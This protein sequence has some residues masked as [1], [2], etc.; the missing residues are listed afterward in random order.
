MS[1]T[2]VYLNLD[3]INND[4]FSNDDPPV[5]RFEETRNAPFLDGDSSE[6][7]A[8]IIRFSIQTGNELPI[9]TPRIETGSTEMDVDRTVYK[10]TVVYNVNPI[11]VPLRWI[12][13]NSAPRPSS[14]VTSQ[15]ISTRYYY[16]NNFT[17]F[18]EML[19][20]ALRSTWVIT[21]ST[22][23]NAPFVDFDSMTNRFNINGDINYFVTGN[24]K[25]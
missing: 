17:Q 24:T 14:P 21:G 4:Q 3:I 1:D 6:Y 8:S 25:L 18:V 23:E 19:N 13:W 2:H 9:F 12:Q 20:N 16:M 5:L 15:D 7:Y 10:V 11:T 22:I